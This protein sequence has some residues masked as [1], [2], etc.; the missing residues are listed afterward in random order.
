MKGLSCSFS[1]ISFNYLATSQPGPP[2][3][4]EGKD[5]EGLSELIEVRERDSVSLSAS[6]CHRKWSLL[7]VI[8]WRPNGTHTAEEVKSLQFSLC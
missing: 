1:N 2:S 8:F 6:P 5:A 3:P 7:N 4:R